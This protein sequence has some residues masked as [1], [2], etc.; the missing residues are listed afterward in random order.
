MTRL[1]YYIEVTIYYWEQN[2]FISNAFCCWQLIKYS[3]KLFENLKTS[4][5]FH[6][7][8]ILF[9]SYIINLCSKRTHPSQIQLV[10][11]TIYPLFHIQT[12][13]EFLSVIFDGDSCLSLLHAQSSIPAGTS[14]RWVDLIVITLPHPIRSHLQSDPLDGHL[15]SNNWSRV[16]PP[17]G[18]GALL[19][20]SRARCA[21]GS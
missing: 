20:T 13:L 4:F 10:K 3:N 2:R 17:G 14:A 21:T 5:V 19:Y 6:S 7:L 16:W 18:V 8:Y 11:S 15:H 9:W 12:L 1:A